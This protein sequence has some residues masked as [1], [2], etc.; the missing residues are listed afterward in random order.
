MHVL[1]VS[2]QDDN[3]CIRKLKYGD[4][5]NFLMQDFAVE[6]NIIFN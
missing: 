6:V 5:S 4:S 3:Q 1:G 2:I